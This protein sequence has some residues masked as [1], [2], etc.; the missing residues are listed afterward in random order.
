MLQVQNHQMKDAHNLLARNTNRTED[1][2]PFFYILV[3]PFIF[4]TNFVA[5]KKL[6]L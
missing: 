1:T 4:L 2:T 3:L 6:S 5:A